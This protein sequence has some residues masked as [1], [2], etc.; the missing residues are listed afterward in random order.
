[1]QQG[2][3]KSTCSEYTTPA[4]GMQQGYDKSTCS[5]YATPAVGMQQGYDKSTAA[6]YTS[7]N[8]YSKWISSVHSNSF[9]KQF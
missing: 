4:L 7:R 8:H 1:M 9:Y 6:L 5:E 3:D 2:Y